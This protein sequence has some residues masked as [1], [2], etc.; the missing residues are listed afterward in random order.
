MSEYLSIVMATSTS[1][2]LKSIED[3]GGV[4]CNCFQDY[5]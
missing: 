1:T 2:V 4:S 3:D 5:V